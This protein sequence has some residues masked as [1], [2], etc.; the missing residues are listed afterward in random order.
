MIFCSFASFMAEV[1][2]LIRPDGVFSDE[3]PVSAPTAAASADETSDQDAEV[4]D[5]AETFEA[6]TFEAEVIEADPADVFLGDEVLD[7]EAATIDGKIT[8]DVVEQDDSS[9]R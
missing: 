4:D 5:E 9:S 7:D 1:R 8:I 6:E 2:E 3:T